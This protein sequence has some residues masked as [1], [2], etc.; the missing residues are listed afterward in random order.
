MNGRFRGRRT[1]ATLL[2]ARIAL[3][4]ARVVVLPRAKRRAASFASR[5]MP[6][7]RPARERD[8]D[9]PATV[10][11]TAIDPS[12][13][14]GELTTSIAIIE[15]SAPPASE[16]ETRDGFAKRDTR[17]VSSAE[18][19]ERGDLTPLSLAE[20][21]WVLAA[22]CALTASYVVAFS[23]VIGFGSTTF[24]VLRRDQKENVLLAV[25]AVIALMLYV[26]DAS[27]W[28]GARTRLARDVFVGVAAILAALSLGLSA[29]RY[30]QA[31]PTLYLV[32]SPLVYSYMRTKVFAHRSLSSYLSAM[33]RSLYA[34]AGIVV[35]CFFVEAS[36]V[37]AWWSTSLELKY[38]D[39]IG[40]DLDLSTD[41]LSAYIMWFSPCLAALASLIFATF[42]A[43][44][45][46]SMRSND[47]QNVLNFT[48]KA[49]GCGLIFVFLGIWVAV[50]IAGGAK[51]LSS[52]LVTFSMAALVVLSG[53]LVATI[54]LDT[55]TS[56]VTSVPLFASIMNAVTENYANVFKAI[57]ISTPLTF[58][59]ALYL[60]LS[61]VNQ[62][63]RAMFGTAP[64]ETSD[65]RWF[66][67]K[68]AKQ[69]QELRD[70]KWSRIMINVHYWIAVVLAFQVIAGSFTIVFLS[71][72]RVQLAAI[73]IALVY[74]IF[75]LVGLAMF[76]IPIIPGLPVY[77]TGGIILT[78]K[79][80]VNALGGGSRGY[81]WA[82]FWAVVLCFVIK[83]LAVVMQQK[84]IGER[85][86]NRVWIRSM[87]NV[88]STTMRSIRYLLTRPG[89]NFPKVA[90]LVGGPDWPTSVTTGI[91]RLSVREMLI[92]TLPVFFLIA[93]TTLAGAFM[94]KASHAANASGIDT[95][96]RE[97]AVSSLATDDTSAWTSIAD[98]G[99]LCTGLAQGLGL[100]AAAYYIEKTAVEAREALDD[101][102]YDEEVLEVE[103]EEAHRNELL[104]A[105]L[106]WDELSKTSRRAL[107]ASTLIVIAAFW[108]IMFGPFF[109]GEEAIVR[110]YLLTDCV[111]TR[112]N[113]KAWNIMTSLG[114]A[115]LA[116]VCA[117]L[118]VVSR[119]NANAK[120]DVDAIIADEEAFMK[121]LE[122]TPKRV[123]DKCPNHDEAINEEKFR[124]RIAAALTTMSRSQIKRVD[125]TMTERELAPFSDETKKF[126]LE[127]IES[128]LSARN[129]ASETNAGAA[130]SA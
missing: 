106:Q 50:S 69:L 62:R 46:S 124:E 128:A 68:V 53:A 64:S 122:G 118:F 100:V 30:P 45:A 85:L 26:T 80:L 54:G 96:C 127:S 14:I 17:Y 32:V 88:N 29:Y 15:P 31:P 126:I 78:D 116:V 87:V 19:F 20:T 22:T 39:A 18:S 77:L 65:S 119:V 108:G 123:W 47:K 130:P 55:I 113:G 41:C 89:L 95:L 67:A 44:L 4:R 21:C 93:P 23:S 57:L 121:E 90:I 52:I 7:W 38:R 24:R 66:T 72:L 36:R 5:V 109:L 8:A 48:I 81:V 16:I 82:C 120:Y 73:P 111:S 6:L 49:F 76:L 97:T 63:V 40:C 13:P 34:C 98:I 105:I 56:K 94:L 51:P 104:R 115:L 112:L 35:M 91:L 75:A 33:A 25:S 12:A 71:Y 92:G 102:P 60:V 125:E 86:G 70:W 37:N 10:R 58:A 114:W 79:P 42:C 43:L 101:I 110:E 84:G 27:H 1:V 103:R 61:I 74:F 3:A 117:S 9:A 28:R 99:L 2:D 83:L 107:L 59:F 11:E 129:K